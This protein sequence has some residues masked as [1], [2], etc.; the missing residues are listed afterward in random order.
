MP[1]L[2]KNDEKIFKKL[3]IKKRG[4]NVFLRYRL[5][6]YEVVTLNP[7]FFLKEI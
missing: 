3:R 1:K 7:L 4:F 2:K 5:K 6:R